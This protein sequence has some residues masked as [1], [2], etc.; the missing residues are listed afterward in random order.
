VTTGRRPSRRAVLGA[1]LAAPFAVG[2]RPARAERALRVVALDYV[3]AEQLIALGAPPI[4]VTDTG[5]WSKWVVEPPLPTGTVDVGTGLA[6]NIEVLAALKPDL[7]LTTDFTSMAEA[8]IRRFAAVER[9]SLFSEGGSP[10]PKATEAMRRMGTLLG[11]EGRANDYLAETERFF[12]AAAGHAARFRDMPVLMLSF[13]DPRHAR[14]YAR[15][16][17]QQD[18]FDRLGL[19]NAWQGEGNVWGFATAGIER[20]AEVGDAR[21]FADYMPDD[22][23][24]VLER[25]PLWRELPVV[26]RA[27]G[28]IPVMPQVL[29]FG[30]VPSARRLAR[31]VLETLEGSAA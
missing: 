7:V 30:G 28:A 9:F 6:P 11:L 17:L 12:A 10:L 21:V 15:P 24:A 27:G 20:L 13:L 16:G 19:A 14:I 3:L 25:S 8:Q 2:L 4:A 23:R 5:E 22:V 31:L 1:A 18:V 26:R 29:P